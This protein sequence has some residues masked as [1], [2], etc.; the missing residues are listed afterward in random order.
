REETST[1]ARL[2][3]SSGFARLGSD[4]R[5]YERTRAGAGAQRRANAPRLRR[6]R[7]NRQKTDEASSSPRRGF[8]RDISDSVASDTRERWFLDSR[9]FNPR[10]R[11]TINSALHVRSPR[12]TLPILGHKRV[13]QTY[14]DGINLQPL[15]VWG[16]PQGEQ[17]PRP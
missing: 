4:A 13:H 5:P 7:S 2:A 10:E 15:N 16:S 1:P 8:G 14:Y 6:T 9:Y 17:R 12:R 3:R 11:R